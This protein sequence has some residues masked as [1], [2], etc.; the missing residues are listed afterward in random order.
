MRALSLS[1]PGD[2]HVPPGRVAALACVATVAKVQAVARLPM[3]RRAATL[4]AFVQMLKASAQ[5][6][7][8]DL[9]DIVVTALFAN[10]AEVGKH[11]RLRTIRDLDGAAL[12]LRQASGVLM[13]DTAEDGAVRGRPSPSCRA[14]HSPRRWSRST[15][16]SDRRAACTSPR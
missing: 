6:D 15:P 16:S 9:F 13:D 11:T 3:E 14:P 7:V 2:S 1:L 12:Q 5:D 10:A 4:L 8:L